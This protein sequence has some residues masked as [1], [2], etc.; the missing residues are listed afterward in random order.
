MA[1]HLF[2][3]A[4]APPL[5]PSRAP[6]LSGAT[7]PGVHK[8]TFSRNCIRR[9][10]EWLAAAVPR[11]QSRDR[12]RRHRQRHRN[13]HKAR[14]EIA[15]GLASKKPELGGLGSI[16]GML[17]VALCARSRP[18][19]SPIRTFM[20]QSRSHGAFSETHL[21]SFLCSR[22]YAGAVSEAEIDV[23]ATQSG[24]T[25]RE[26]LR[27]KLPCRPIRLTAELGRHIGYLEAHIEQGESV[28]KLGAEDRHRHLHRRHLEIPH[29]IHWRSRIRW[30][31][32]D[33]RAPGMQALA[34][35]IFCVEILTIAFPRLGGPRRRGLLVAS[36]SIRVRRASSRAAPKCCSNPRS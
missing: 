17:G 18:L 2:C 22:S 3:V 19:G 4:C 28:Q 31:D 6:R 32:A 8:P 30:H 10:L 20:A 16:T 36:R 21:C 25:M 14:A 11:P 27:D 5:P 23:P 12:N 1:D 7:R 33:G 24:K 13:Q 34:L 29:H 26:A 15:G 35:A 9:S